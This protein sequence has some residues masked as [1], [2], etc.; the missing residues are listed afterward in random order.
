MTITMT[1]VGPS[2]ESISGEEMN[3]REKWDRE[4]EHKVLNSSDDYASLAE[5]KENEI[6][7]R[8]QWDLQLIR[9]RTA[10]QALKQ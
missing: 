1:A 5:E 2:F 7:I 4:F 10:T 8:E 3:R 9:M 6:K